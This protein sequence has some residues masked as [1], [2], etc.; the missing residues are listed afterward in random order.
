MSTPS[1]VTVYSI[2]AFVFA[3]ASTAKQVSAELKDSSKS[4]GY[5]IIA[6]AVVEV[7]SKGKAHIHEAGHGRWGAGLGAVTGGALGLI[8]GPAGLLAWTVAGGVIGGFAGKIEGRAIPKKDLEKLASTMVPGTSAIL[9]MVEDT[10]SEALIKGVS[11]YQ[12]DV[13][14]LAIG[15][16]ISGEIALGI[17]VEASPEEA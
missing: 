6:N 8:G 14:T 15:D 3:D 11:G 2:L 7:D 10:Q 12:A 4:G 13:V 1:N 9:A 16:E 17:V 5:T